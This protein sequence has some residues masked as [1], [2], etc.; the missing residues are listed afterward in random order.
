MKK[1]NN[2]IPLLAILFYFSIGAILL[3]SSC[4]NQNNLNGPSNAF[5]VKFFDLKGFINTEIGRLAKKDSFKKTVYINGASEEKKVQSLN[6]KNEMKPFLN[7][8]IN[9]PAWTDKYLTDSLFNEKQELISLTY[10]ALDST[11]RT[12][13]LSI[14]FEK[15][16]SAKCKFGCL[17]FGHVQL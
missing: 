10:S 3:T 11:L 16:G 7:S 8:D 15:N 13:S 2:L 9:K 17:Y 14:E 1:N 5:E 6:L 4:K 12:Q